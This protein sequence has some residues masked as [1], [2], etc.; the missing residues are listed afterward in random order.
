MHIA[1]YPY[2]TYQTALHTVQWYDTPLSP[3][4]AK[5][6]K[7]KKHRNISVYNIARIK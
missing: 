6:P 3:N 2:N 1:S 5:R 7:Q 4:H